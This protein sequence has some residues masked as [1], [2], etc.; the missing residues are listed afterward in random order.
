MIHFEPVPEPADFHDGART[1]GT[2]WL[3]AHP[4]AKRPPRLL[5][6]LQRGRWHPASGASA[7]YSAMYEPVGTVDSLRELARRPIEGVRV[8]TTIAIAPDGINSSK[9]KASSATL[10]DPYEIENGWFE[11][12]LPSLQLRI[13]DTIP[14]AFRER[15]EHTL[16]RLHLRDDERVLRQRQEWHRMYRSGELTLEGLWKKAP[17]IAKAIADQDGQDG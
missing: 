2:A 1:P 8:G 17:L 9:Q 6:S 16:T 12:L 13:S 11:L 14:D 10:F 4:E 7:P 15:A 5:D 3:A